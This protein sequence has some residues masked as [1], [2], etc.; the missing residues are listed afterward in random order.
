MEKERKKQ[1]KAKKFAEK[2]M[3]S[4]NNEAAP[5]VSKN[6]EKK[7]KQQAAKEDPLPDYKEETPVGEKKSTS[8]QRDNKM[9]CLPD[10]I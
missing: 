7:A 10:H 3:K 1:D 5:T 8:R 6:K 9:P 2:Q 4:L